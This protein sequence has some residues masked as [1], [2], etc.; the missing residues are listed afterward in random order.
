MN[1]SEIKKNVAE[2]IAKSEKLSE[3]KGDIEQLVAKFNEADEAGDYKAKA[4]IDAELSETVSQYAT[5]AQS[6]VFAAIA[7]VSDN[8]LPAILCYD[9]PVIVT[10]QSYLKE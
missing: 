3:L 2:A 6:V 4:K 8:L 1:Q 7:A 10:D 9:Y 5:N